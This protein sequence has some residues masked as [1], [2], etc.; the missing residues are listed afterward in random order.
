VTAT[1]RSHHSKPD[2]LSDLHTLTTNSTSRSGGVDVSSGSSGNLQ[3]KLSTHSMSNEGFRDV[4]K[5][6]AGISP[7]NLPSITHST[8]CGGESSS[9]SCSSSSNSNYNYWMEPVSTT[10]RLHEETIIRDDPDFYNESNRH[11]SDDDVD[12]DDYDDSDDNDDSDEY[13]N[14]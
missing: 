10:H 5:V 4:I 2:D 7:Y 8:I 1:D 12:S 13:S 6:L 14:V 9:S 11:D 3:N